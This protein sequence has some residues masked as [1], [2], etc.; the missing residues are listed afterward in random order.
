MDGVLT[1]Q[2][3]ARAAESDP[4]CCG[5]V[6][7]VTENWYYWK[8][9]ETGFSRIFRQ[10]AASVS[11]E[12]ETFYMQERVPAV[13]ASAS[14][15]HK[16][17]LVAQQNAEREGWE[18]HLKMMNQTVKPSLKKH[19]REAIVKADEI[20]SAKQQQQQQVV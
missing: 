2:E 6:R 10:D 11:G 15:R 7:Q 1:V 18:W 16:V 17:A 4:Q 9:A 14:E 12:W 19:W 20:Y 5:F 8:R 3:A 13:S